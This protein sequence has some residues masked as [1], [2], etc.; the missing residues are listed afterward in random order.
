MKMHYRKAIIIAGFLASGSAFAATETTTLNVSATVSGSCS[1]SA[2]PAAFG[3]ISGLPG[4]EFVANGNIRVNCSSGTS[5]SVG[6]DEGQNFDSIIRAMVNGS[7]HRINYIIEESGSRWGNAGTP[8]PVT[9]NQPARN[10][11][12]TGTDQTFSYI[13]RAN[14]VGMVTGGN[15]FTPG[16]TYNDVVNVTVHF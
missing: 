15:T 14:G 13:A 8:G 11:V 4:E 9:F 16:T 6:L 1:V 10:G 7:N 3:E 2:D 12:G 5:Y